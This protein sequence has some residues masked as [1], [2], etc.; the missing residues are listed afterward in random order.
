MQTNRPIFPAEKAQ[1]NE[2]TF[3]GRAIFRVNR[4]TL[5]SK[6]LLLGRPP[7]SSSS[8]ISSSSSLQYSGPSLISSPHPQPRWFFSCLVLPG[9]FVTWPI[10][11]G[12]YG[13]GLFQYLACNARLKAGPIVHGLERSKLGR[14]WV[15]GVGNSMPQ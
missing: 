7:F 3:S 5:E 12:A 11:V 2:G 8:S 9:C 13:L 4:P 1:E 15:G 6:L 14:T 10:I